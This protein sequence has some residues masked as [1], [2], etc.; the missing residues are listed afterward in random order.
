MKVL[1]ENSFFWQKQFRKGPQ[2]L[3]DKG[4]S[5]INWAVLK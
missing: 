4:Y 5:T 3:L 1:A 2:V